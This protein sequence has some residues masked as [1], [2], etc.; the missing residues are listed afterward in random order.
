MVKH[1]YHVFHVPRRF[2]L[3]TI[4]RRQILPGTCKVLNMRQTCVA[5]NLLITHD[6]RLRKPCI[7]SNLLTASQ[8][9]VTGVQTWP[10]NT[11]GARFSQ[12]ALC[13]QGFRSSADIFTHV[14]LEK[15]LGAMW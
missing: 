13:I 6:P 7:S 15:Y 4:D 8:G 3:Q 11:R 10:G 2:F 12:F 5:F 14:I 9:R 1:H